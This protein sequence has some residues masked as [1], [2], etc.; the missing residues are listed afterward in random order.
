MFGTAGGARVKAEDNE[1][2]AARIEAHAT[3]LMRK[4]QNLVSG[5]LSGNG[6]AEQAG[7]PDKLVFSLMSAL[8]ADSR[9]NGTQ[10]VMT[11]N[12][13]S[14][15]AKTEADRLREAVTFRNMTLR[16]TLPL[17]ASESTAP[18]TEAIAKPTGGDVSRF[19]MVL[20][21]SLLD[22]T[23]TRL[24]SNDDCYETLLALVPFRQREQG[25][26]IDRRDYFD[27]CHRRAAYKQRV[28]LRLAA[29][30][31]NSAGE[32]PT[33]KNTRLELAALAV[34]WAPKPWFYANAFGQLVRLPSQLQ[35]YGLGFSFGRNFGKHDSG[36]DAWLRLGLDVLGIAAYTPKSDGAPSSTATEI[37]LTP[38][39]RARVLGSGI[40]VLGV[41]PRFLGSD[42]EHPALLASLA[43]TYDADQL[44]DQQLVNPLE[45]APPST[46][47]NGPVVH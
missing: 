24:P 46:A 17:S 2:K 25:D 7:S 31:V 14:L 45:S 38:N 5:A 33:S 13:A 8:G 34:V 21:T 41:G 29:G 6:F 15:W 27:I 23:D 35:V 18:T 32:Q 43:L 22:E 12:L 10:L 3:D 11:L 42:P 30:F 28:S 4:G 20:G 36:V 40:L 37:R 1:A 9:T 39:V 47:S 44:I 19:S 16:A 26:T